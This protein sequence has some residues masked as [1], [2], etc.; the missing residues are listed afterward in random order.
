M[1]SQWV[2]KQQMNLTGTLLV[3][4]TTVNV[5]RSESEANLC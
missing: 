3:V 1:G 4:V 2:A 5:S